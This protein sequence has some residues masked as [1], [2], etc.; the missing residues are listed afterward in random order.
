[1]AGN[2]ESKK[3]LDIK[4]AS[5][6][7]HWK[8]PT[9]DDF[10]PWLERVKSV[11]Y[12]GVTCFAFEGLECFLDKPELLSRSLN[13]SGMDLA[14]VDIPLDTPQDDYKRVMDLMNEANCKQLACI[15]HGAKNKTPELYKY[16]ADMLNRT[17]EYAS[18]RGICV[19][20]HNNSDSIGRNFTDWKN[21]IPLIDW[22]L[23]Y[24]MADTGHVTKDFD[25]EPY[26]ERAIKHLKDNW[27]RVHYLEFKDYNTATDLNTPLGEGFCDFERI[28]ALMKER[29]YTGWITIEQNGVSLERSADEC[30]LISRNF[31]RKGLGI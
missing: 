26:S 6:G 15:V 9:G 21:L 19:H 7:L 31:V 2:F 24:F 11:G 28:F 27:D 30:A 4:W 14:A 25:E 10:E 1:M 16:Y 29:G 18:K 5:M 20:L 8:N 13:N 17:G 22:N 12:D 23:V 3:K